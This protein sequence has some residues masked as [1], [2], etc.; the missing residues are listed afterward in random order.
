MYDFEMKNVLENSP[1]NG[2]SGYHFE[3]T[4]LVSERY[5]KNKRLLDIGCGYGWWEWYCVKKG[6]KEVVGIDTSE[7]ELQTARKIKSKLIT[8]K[9]ASAIKL[10]FMNQSFDTAVSWEVIEHIPIN[11]EGIMFKE[12]FR[13]LKKGGYFFLSTQQNNPV[14]TVLDPAW[15]FT[16]H[17]HYSKSR[18]VSFAKAAGFKVERIYTKGGFYAILF[19]LNMYVARWIFGKPI[20][21]KS[22]FVLKTSEEFEKKKGFVNVFIKCKK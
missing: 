11:T 7:K 9:K 3:T 17:R 13:V 22:F 8:L 1:F 20:L 16:G 21:F 2:L 12:V 5:I 19:W 14:S 15:W 10:P 18:I 4:R 6:I